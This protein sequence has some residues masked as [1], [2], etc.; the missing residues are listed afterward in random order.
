MKFTKSFSTLLM[1]TTTLAAGASAAL[2]AMEESGVFKP[3]TLRDRP[4]DEFRSVAAAVDVRDERDFQDNYADDIG[5]GVFFAPGVTVNGLDIQEPRLAIRGFGVGNSAQRSNV[6]ILRDGAPLTDIHGTTNTTEIDLLSTRSIDIVRGVGNLRQAGGNLG[7]VVN[8]VSRTGRNTPAGLSARLYGGATIDGKPGGQTHINIA[9]ASSKMDYYAGVTGVYETGW[10]DNNRR[11]S[12]QFNGNIG[13]NLG[14]DLDTRFFVDVANSKTELAGGLTLAELNEDAQRPTPPISLGPLFPGGPIIN[15]VDG[16]RA[17]DFARDIREGRIANETTF[18]LLWHDFTI[19]GHYTRR[20]VESPQIDFIGFLDQEGSE[21]G[22]RL[23]AERSLLLFGSDAQYRI[24]GAWMDGSQTSDVFEN[25]NGDP[26]PV[27]SQTDQKSKLINAFVEGVYKPL[28]RLAVDIG[29]KF[30]KV[31]RRLTDFADDDV[32]TESFT[33]VAARAGA[34]FD[35]SDRLQFYA[36]ASRAYEPPTMEQLTAGD[37]TQLSDLEEQDSFTLEAGLRGNFGDWV[38]F[39]VAYYDTDVENE[40]ISL[41]EPSSFISGAVYG[42]ANST[43]HKGAEVGIDVHLFPE[44]M[45]NRGAALTLRNVYNY[46][47]HRFVDGGSLGNVDGNRIA[48]LP[49]HH[50]RGELRY[51][52]EDAWFFAANVQLSGGAYFADH[53]N[54]VSVPTDPVIGFS[55]GYRLNDQLEIFA[56]GENL[57]DTG[58]IAGV[59]PVLSINIDEDRIFTPGARASVYGGLKY[60]F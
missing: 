1:A 47:N 9:G 34:R 40:I 30:I 52:I 53:E 59:S 49:V 18:G 10:R 4:L 29:A 14:S 42:N 33:G 24:G 39:N 31:D 46:A 28:Q 55:A 17:D 41:A 12:Q 13:F 20:E 38:G 58:Y 54:T 32:D 8:L 44:A 60:R 23:E 19:G 37:E 5:D 21:W 3:I 27:I 11:S 2:A 7:G 50:Y 48:G 45:A 56:S 15:L 22:A 57:L 35:I 26:G 43:T 51:D 16:A 25:L 36:S 6:L